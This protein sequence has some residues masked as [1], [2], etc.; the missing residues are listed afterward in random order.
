M[1]MKVTNIDDKM[2]DL[3]L[4]KEKKKKRTNITT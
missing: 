4:N 3:N 1:G 2:I